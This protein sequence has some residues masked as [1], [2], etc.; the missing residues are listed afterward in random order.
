MRQIRSD[1]VRDEPMMLINTLEF[2][3]AQ[4]AKWFTV[5][6]FG[7][8]TATQQESRCESIDW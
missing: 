4:T 1:F 8:M 2:T 7:S 5:I 6:F 3:T